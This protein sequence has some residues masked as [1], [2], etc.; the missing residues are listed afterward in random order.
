MCCVA[1]FCNVPRASDTSIVVLGFVTHST[2]RE[3][4]QSCLIMY[5][6]CVRGK[7]NLRFDFLIHI[8]LFP[9]RFNRL[10]RR[11][12]LRSRDIDLE[13]VASYGT[14]SSFVNY[15]APLVQDERM[16]I[17]WEPV[18]NGVRNRRSIACVARRRAIERQR[19][20]DAQV[21]HNESLTRNK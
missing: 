8:N 5:I 20:E 9:L 14:M 2:V 11:R 3:E 7:E 18:K 17:A 1:P 16:P 21:E 6:Y 15:F 13:G 10:R 12:A 19:T 4:L